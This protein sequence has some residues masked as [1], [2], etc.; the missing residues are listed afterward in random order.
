MVP[1]IL[2]KSSKTVVCVCMCQCYVI[3]ILCVL[4]ARFYRI[5]IIY[6]HSVMHR[7]RPSYSTERNVDGRLILDITFA[8]SPTP[9]YMPPALLTTRGARM[10]MD[11]CWSKQARQSLSRETRFL[12]SLLAV[13][14]S[15]A[16]CL[17]THG[18]GHGLLPWPTPPLTSC[19]PSTR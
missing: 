3:V 18:R 14:S 17:L 6:V 8:P 12:C 4:T 11:T 16:A 7:Y 2:Q 5:K 10:S 9:R 13:N 15:E 19:I 1:D